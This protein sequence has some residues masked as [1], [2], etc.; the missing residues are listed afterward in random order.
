VTAEKPLL[1]CVVCGQ[2]NATRWQFPSTDGVTL[3]IARCARCGH[4]YQCPRLDAT[5]GREQFRKAYTGELPDQ[6]YFDPQKKQEH[7]RRLWQTVQRQVGTVDRL[8]D[9]GAG[10]G[11]FVHVVRA[12]GVEA[13]GLEVS[14]AGVDRARELFGLELFCGPLA[15]LPPSAPFDV[16]TL[17]DVI[18]H[19]PHPD[20]LL[21]EAAERLRDNG[22]LMLSTGNYCSIDRLALGREW[23][24]W[25]A[26]HYHY[27]SPPGMRRL[28]ERLG[29]TDFRYAREP[30]LPGG[31]DRDKPRSGRGR[32]R[33]DRLLR[34]A[35]LASKG[36][37]ALLRWPRYW[38]AAVMTCAM[39]RP[40][41]WSPP[42][43]PPD[44][45]ETGL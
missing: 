18:E 13:Q 14:Q 31:W 40:T 44:E 23:Y 2:A 3:S 30:R 19:C 35:W 7:A 22:W 24:L 15:E 6:G 4:V 8:L 42:R 38:N 37:I 36:A 20:R 10:L 28:A 43:P 39:R 21:L 9:V 45:T 25:Q 27:F 11:A 17:W 29:L 41:G 12:A 5:I 16:V 32:F 34:F 26:D 1:P 33:P